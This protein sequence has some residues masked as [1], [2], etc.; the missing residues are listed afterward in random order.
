MKTLITLVTLITILACT[1]EPQQIECNT[2]YTDWQLIQGYWNSQTDNSS[3]EIH[4]N[5]MYLLTDS[6]THLFSWSLTTKTFK[7]WTYDESTQL[8]YNFNVVLV[9]DSTLVLENNKKHYYKLNQ[10]GSQWRFWYSE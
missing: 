3:L 2:S 4:N 7:I 1:K 9:D 5:T 6:I 8:I 10:L